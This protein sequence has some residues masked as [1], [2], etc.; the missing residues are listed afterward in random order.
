MFLAALILFDMSVS[1]WFVFP[2][3]FFF[4]FLLPTPVASELQFR[5][6]PGTCRAGSSSPGPSLALLPVTTADHREGTGESA[7][8]KY[9]CC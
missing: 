5:T 7:G 6:F 9:C 8:L 1:D 4:P 3:S 2:F